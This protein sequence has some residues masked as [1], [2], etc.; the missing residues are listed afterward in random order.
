MEGNYSLARKAARFSFFAPLAIAVLW[1][2]LSPLTTASFAARMVCA[3]TGSLLIS[4]ALVCAGYA[5]IATKKCGRAGILIFAASG[6][7]LNCLLIAATVRTAQKNRNRPRVPLYTLTQ[8]DHMLPV[9]EG[10]QSYIDEDFGFR[11][12]LPEAFAENPEGTTMPNVIHAF[13]RTSTNGNQVVVINRLGSMLDPETPAA[14]FVEKQITQLPPG[15]EVEAF[16]AQWGPFEVPGVD[17]LLQGQQRI[18]EVQVPLTGEAV[19]INIGGPEA[20]QDELRWLLDNLLKS[21]RARSNWEALLPP[22]PAP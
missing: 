20:M 1:L 22:T 15:S 13:I 12:E 2:V 9:L 3:I 18:L 5:L 21:L 11:F 10:S 19:Q 6:L 16:T 4:V 7:L 8:L 14:D 17:V